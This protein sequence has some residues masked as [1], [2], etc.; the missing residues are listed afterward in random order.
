MATIPLSFFGPFAGIIGHEGIIAINVNKYFMDDCFITCF[1]C[2]GLF[3]NGVRSRSLYNTSKDFREAL[4]RV[5]GLR[6]FMIGDL[7]KRLSSTTVLLVFDINCFVHRN[8]SAECGARIV[9]A[10][11]LAQK[12]GGSPLPAYAEILVQD[13]EY[14]DTRLRTQTTL[15]RMA[16]DVAKSNLETFGI[17]FSEDDIL[18]LMMSYVRE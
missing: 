17:K 15:H 16:Q 2:D 11:R 4:H 9:P 10:G 6:E 18:A 1:E 14:A 3:F 7:F 5:G 8:I 13:D 12:I